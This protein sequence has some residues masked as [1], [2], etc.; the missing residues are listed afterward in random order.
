[1]D[2]AVGALEEL[3]EGPLYT[4]VRFDPD[5]FEVLHVADATHELYPDESAMCGHFERIFDYVGIDFAE[6]ALFTDVLLSGAGEVT[7]M[8]TSLD[9]VKVVRAYGDDAT[10]VFLAVDPEESVPRLVEAVTDHLL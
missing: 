1:M 3:A 5:D 8:T 6:R 2:A 4:L 9:S 7:Y 10:G